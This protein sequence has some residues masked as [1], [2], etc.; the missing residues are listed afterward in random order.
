MSVFPFL[1]PL[2]PLIGLLDRSF[3]ITG[4][5]LVF[6]SWAKHGGLFPFILFY[7]FLFPTRLL[8]CILE[9]H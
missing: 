5:G 6:L 9:Q 7:S 4:W 3:I 2:L 8:V 1:L